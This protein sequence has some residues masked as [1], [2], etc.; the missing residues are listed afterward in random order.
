[1]PLR[2]PFPTKGCSVGANAHEI[3]RQRH[4]V[5]ALQI[6]E[7]RRQLGLTQHEVVDRLADLGITATN[8]T[9][10]AIEHGQG[11]D[12][13]R[14]PELA[15]A[16]NCTVTYL[17]G[18]TSEPQSWLPDDGAAPSTTAEKPH[19]RTIPGDQGSWLHYRAG[20]NAVAEGDAEHGSWHHGVWHHPH[21]H[22]HDGPEQMNSAQI[23]VRAGSGLQRF[24]APVPEPDPPAKRRA[25][26]PARTQARRA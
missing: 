18:L 17:L 25:F 1:M 16:L 19:Q 9:L 20:E 10:S 8:R 6:A 15:V 4:W 24:A 11:V 3:N 14:L 5:C 12:V 13:G 7:R 21:G 23:T 26:P 2:A 22:G